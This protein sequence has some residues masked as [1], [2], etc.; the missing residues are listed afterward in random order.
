MT[1][2]IE[3]HSLQLPTGG[4]F[5]FGTLPQAH[6][7]VVEG[8]TVAWLEFGETPESLDDFV[9]LPGGTV[10]RAG[11]ERIDA[12]ICGAEVGGA[13]Q[14]N[15]GVVIFADRIKRHAEADGQAGGLRIALGG[16]AEN[17]DGRL[18][19]AMNQEF[20]GPVE[21]IA[22]T[23]VHVRGDFEV[24]GSGDEVAVFLLDFG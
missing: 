14:G 9:G 8:A 7:V 20:A 10:V 24:V 4:R 13:Q 19:R 12:S 21:E 5:S 15:D 22:L 3:T 1:K 2:I 6:G 11:E 16:L 18:E 23:G 17:F